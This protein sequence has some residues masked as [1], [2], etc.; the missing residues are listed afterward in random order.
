MQIY[1]LKEEFKSPVRDYEEIKINN[2][3]IIQVLQ[4]NEVN[5]YVNSFL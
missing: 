1:T 4:T 5:S 2:I 3:E